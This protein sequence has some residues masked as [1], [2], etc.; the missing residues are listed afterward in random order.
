[1]HNSGRKIVTG[2][3]ENMA[4]LEYF[5]PTV[6][7]QSSIHDE[8]KNRFNSGNACCQSIQTALSPPFLFT[9]YRFDCR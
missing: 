2:A 7:C 5:K 8:I 9:Y 3:S 6:A 4:K 1:M